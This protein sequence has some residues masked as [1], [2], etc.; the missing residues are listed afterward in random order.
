MATR[1]RFAILT[2]ALALAASAAQAQPAG[3]RITPDQIVETV[4]EIAAS[5]LWRL[6][7]P[8]YHY[9]RI[10]KPP[11]GVIGVWTYGRES[12]L[13]RDDWF[14]VCLVIDGFGDIAETPVA[15]RVWGRSSGQVSVAERAPEAGTVQTF[16]LAVGSGRLVLSHTALGLVYVNGHQVGEIR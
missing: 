6:S 9:G 15:V 8:E 16:E 11:G 4:T 7:T 10:G 12:Q 14:A 2:P 5:E 3:L 1:A 13:A